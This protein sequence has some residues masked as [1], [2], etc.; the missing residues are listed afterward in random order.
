[1]E[2]ACAFTFQ[3]RS[4]GDEKE[5]LIVPEGR[6]S[7]RERGKGKGERRIS[8]TSRWNKIVVLPGAHEKLSRK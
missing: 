5:L 3:D 8:W 7:W 6:E 4:Y 2:S 1:M